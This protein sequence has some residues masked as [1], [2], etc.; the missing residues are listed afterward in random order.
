MQAAY[1]YS[2]NE[3]KF[4][5]YYEAKV[6]SEELKKNGRGVENFGDFKSQPVSV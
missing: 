4:R 1:K 3:K 5:S 2:V 6:L